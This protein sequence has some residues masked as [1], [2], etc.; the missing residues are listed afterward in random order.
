MRRFRSRNAGKSFIQI[1]FKLHNKRRNPCSYVVSG[2]SRIA[3][4]EELVKFVIKDH[5]FQASSL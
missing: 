5:T 1:F 4:R 2:D 3:D